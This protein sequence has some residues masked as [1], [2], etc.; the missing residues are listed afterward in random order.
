MKTRKRTGGHGSEKR[1]TMYLARMDIKTALDVA[2]MGDQDSHGWTTAALLRE[3]AGEGEALGHVDSTFP[4]TRCT[5]Q[6]CS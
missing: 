6:G 1:P 4:F 2:T 5:R 3:M